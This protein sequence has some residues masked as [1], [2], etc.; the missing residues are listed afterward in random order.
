MHGIVRITLKIE[1]M[2]ECQ[3]LEIL[4]LYNTMQL[5]LKST[6]QS[7]AGDRSLLKNFI[8]SNANEAMQPQSFKLSL[9]CLL[10]YG[11]SCNANCSVHQ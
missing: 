5:E 10:L 7:Y 2:S 1:S 11:M 9:E 8:Y 6:V 3:E 4:K